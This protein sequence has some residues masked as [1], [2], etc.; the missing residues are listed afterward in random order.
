LSKAE[1]GSLERS[2]R[3]KVVSRVHE[4]I[5]NR[6]SN[7]AHQE[8]RKLIDRFGILAFEELNALLMLKNHCL[9]ASP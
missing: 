7:F 1:K 3:R 8:S 4:R 6:R 5:A 9:G 2:S